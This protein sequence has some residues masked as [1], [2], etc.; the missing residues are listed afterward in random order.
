MDY[1]IIAV[2][3]ACLGSFV[4]AA[5]YRL[6]RGEDIFFDKS[7]CPSC[8]NV[9][10][11]RDLVPIFSWLWNKAKCSNC[12]AKI[13]PRYVITE[14]ITTLLALGLLYKYGLTPEFGLFLALAT[15]L[16]ILIVAD[17]ETYIIP[18]TSTIG[19]LVLGVPYVY[20]FQPNWHDNIWGA[21]AGLVIALLLR[22]GYQL[23]M[24]KEGLG[25]GD[26]KFLPVAGL[27]VGLTLLPFYFVL[28]GL[29]GIA[30]AIWWKIKYKNPLF[31]FG[32]ALAVAMLITCVFKDTLLN[33]IQL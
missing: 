3:G 2:V 32:P 16:M 17:F 27:W 6:P 19:A 11:P 30:T 21:L 4:T 10:G 26:V 1:F 7:R 15:L 20:Y 23:F 13:S 28:G 22:Y 12:K 14:I 33:I 29:L 24:K 5:S 18:D 31:P 25:M 8:K 9:L